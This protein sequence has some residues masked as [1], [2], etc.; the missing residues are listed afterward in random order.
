MSNN[1]TYWFHEEGKDIVSKMDQMRRGWLTYGTNPIYQ[2]WIR[3]MIAYYST[4][5][6]ATAWDTGLVFSGEQGELVEMSVPQARS[7]IRQLVGLITKQKLAFSATAEAKGRDVI[8]ASRLANSLAAQEVTQHDLDSKGDMLIEMAMVYGSSFIHVPWRSDR[9]EPFEGDTVTKT[10]GEEVDRILY[11]GENDFQILGPLDLVYDY[12]MDSW[13]NLDWVEAR[14]IQN[15]WNLIAQ[16]PELEQK[17]IALPSVRKQTPLWAYTAENFEEHDTIY[18]YV[19]YHK[20]TPALPQGRMLVYADKDTIMFDDHN[21]YKR[22]PIV[23]CMPEKVHGLLMGY[24]VLSSLLPA[25]EMLDHSFSAIATNQAA[26]A[27]QNIVAPR[28]SG[29]TVEDIG[30]MNFISFTPQQVDGG[31]KPE[32]LQL[33]KSAPET[34]NFIPLL[35]QHMQQISNLNSTVRG[36]PPAGMKA[37]VAIATL[38]ANA[39]ELLNSHSKA[40]VGA[41]ERAM[42]HSVRNFQDFGHLP[43]TVNMKGK[44][45]QIL[46]KEFTNKDLGAIKGVKIQAQNPLM[47]TI[48]GRTEVAEKL[49]PTGLLKNAQE[50]FSI[51]EGEPVS[52]M[53]EVELSENDLLHDE[54]ESMIEGAPVVALSTDDHPVHIRSHAALLNKSSVRTD[55]ARVQSIL[56]HILEHHQLSQST[57]PMLTAM[58]RTGKMPMQ[59]PPAPMGAP[60]AGGMASQMAAG[61]EQAPAQPAEDK[62]GRM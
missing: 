26:H 61:P 23:P 12:R 15:R 25:Q 5:L 8:E 2:T 27:V 30:G 17:L 52:T 39:L 1:T 20:P 9:G 56:D 36:E 62:L 13:E 10:N 45:G 16:F 59:G 3:N 24:P 22:I 35:L 48:A 34:F 50:Y 53:W 38:T 31:G 32:A 33:T 46:A 21:P 7:L 57:D 54:N 11:T 58:V 42:T 19:N 43:H 37:G 4:I 29:L 40:Y 49:L 41:W 47:S 14:T 60:G 28:G 55:N 51:L 18:V 44:G 6:K